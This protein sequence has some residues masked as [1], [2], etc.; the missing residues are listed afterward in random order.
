MCVCVCDK[1]IR[2]ETFP[3]SLSERVFSPTAC[4]KSYVKVQTKFLEK[5]PEFRFHETASV[6]K[7]KVD[8]LRF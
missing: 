2:Y 8:N 3:D 5:Y 4:S 1:S 7:K 6:T